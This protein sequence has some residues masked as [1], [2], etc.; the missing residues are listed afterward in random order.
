LC[1]HRLQTHLKVR[2]PLEPSQPLPVPMTMMNHHVYLWLSALSRLD[3][4]EWNLKV[5]CTLDVEY[6]FFQSVFG[7]IDF[8][9][10]HFRFSPFCSMLEKNVSYLSMVY[11]IYTF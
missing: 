9:Q 10:D 1:D 3:I 7:I 5:Y 6:I 4:K 8:G 2:L 11:F